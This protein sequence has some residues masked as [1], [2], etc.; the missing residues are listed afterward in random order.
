MNE[1]QLDSLFENAPQMPPALADQIRARIQQNG[2]HIVQASLCRTSK[3][4][5][6]VEVKRFDVDTEHID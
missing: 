4:S 6:T 2:R 5:I 3:R 1:D